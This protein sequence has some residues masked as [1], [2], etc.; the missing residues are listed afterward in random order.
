MS[1]K[2]KKDAKSVRVDDWFSG[3][4]KELEKRMSEI[5]EDFR[6]SRTKRAEINRNLISDF[7]KIWKT[8]NKNGILF[9]IEPNY[10]AFAQFD[11]FPYG[12][13]R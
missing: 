7:W 11:D 6:E 1:A 3:I 5:S 8:F 12:K 2:A 10:T 4:D 13:I 9:S